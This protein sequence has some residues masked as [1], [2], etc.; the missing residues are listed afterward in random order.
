VHV[1]ATDAVTFASVPLFLIGVAMVACWLPARRVAL[2]SPL[3]SLR[4]E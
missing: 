2:A 4:D 3:P 1:S